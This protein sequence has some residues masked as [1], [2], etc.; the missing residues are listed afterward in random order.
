MLEQTVVLA[1]RK[2][3]PVHVD[4]RGGGPVVAEVDTVRIERVLRNLV[5]NA[6][7][8]G[9]GRPVEVT[10]AGDERSVAVLVRDHGVGLRPEESERVFTRF[11][12]GDPSRARTTGGTGLGLAIAL[13]D[14]RLHGGRL[15]A[16]GRPGRGAAFRLTL[17]HRVGA[18]RTRAV[19]SRWLSRPAH[20]RCPRGAAGRQP[21]A[22]ARRR[23]RSG[24]GQPAV[25]AGRGTGR[26][27]LCLVLLLALAG[28][29]L[30]RAGGVQRPGE[31]AA[32]QRLPEPINV[33]PPGPQPG[34]TPEEVVLGFLAAQSSGR[35]RHGIARSFLA[36]DA[37]AGWRDDA[38]VVVHDPG[39]T[40]AESSA[41]LT[42]RTSW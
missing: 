36:P 37:R 26:A 17:P 4:V 39:K 42:A 6:L 25:R 35:D 12:R 21:R 29:G 30:P 10:V 2:G 23:D 33:L 24:P 1:E 20:D 19:R 18:E 34:A 38:G 31:V 16:W 11:W 13:E 8:H 15:E 28:C 5:V 22:R 3:S 41:R 9:E 32:E 27:L 40:S 14:A 7:E